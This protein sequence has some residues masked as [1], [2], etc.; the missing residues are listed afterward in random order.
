[1][2]DLAK[3]PLVVG[4]VYLGTLI[5]SLLLLLI[6]FCQPITGFEG[7]LFAYGA[8]QNLASGIPYVFAFI[9]MIV[10][11]IAIASLGLAVYSLI[12][13]KNSGF[14][15]SNM[16]IAALALGSIIYGVVFKGLNGTAI[17][18][19]IAALVFTIIS[20]A[21][22]VYRKKILGKIVTSQEPLPKKA[23]NLSI[24]MLVVDVLELIGLFT[25]F[26]IPLY[27]TNPGETSSISL[28]LSN[29]L[30]SASNNAT[31]IFLFIGALILFLISIFT[32]LTMIPSFFSD[33]DQFVRSSTVFTGF[34]VFLTL[35]FFLTG[36][37]MSYYV[38]TTGT[39]TSTIAYVPLIVIGVLSLAVSILKGQ[40]DLAT[41]KPEDNQKTVKENKKYF[42]VEPLIYLGLM[43]VMTFVSLAL[44]VIKM[45]IT[46]GSYIS[47]ITLTGYKLLTSYTT[48]G[49]GYQ[50]LAV[51][52]V[53]MLVASGFCLLWSLV[54]FFTHYPFFGRVVKVSAYVNVFLMFLLGISGFYFT[55]AQEINKT[56]LQSLLDLYNISI[57]GDYTYVLSTDAFYALIVDAVLLSVMIIR[58]AFNV[59]EV[60]P[61]AD[62][63]NSK[64]DSSADKLGLGEPAD[65]SSAV[66]F[67]PCPAFTEI[68]KKKDDYEADLK[69]REKLLTKDDSLNGLVKFVVNYAKDSRLHLSYSIEDMATFVSGLGACRLSILQGMS[70]TGKTSLP[71][72]FMEAIDG[73]CDLVEVESSWKDKNELL[74]Y[75]NEFSYMFTPRKFTQDLYKAALNPD[76][77]TF[78]VLDEMNL[79]RI[80]Y[81]FSDFLSLME[82]EEDKRYLKLSNI[83]LEK[84]VEGEKST[85]LAL[86]DGHTLKVPKN[87]WFIGTANRDE[88]TFIISDKVYDRAHT[89]NFNKRAPKVRDY[90]DPLP[91]QFYTYDKL[92][93]MLDKAIKSGTFDAEKNELIQKTEALLIPYN[94]SFG[95]RILNQIETFVN[96]YQAC[97]PDKNVLNQAIE[98]ILFSKVVSKLEMKTIDDKEGLAK[99]FDKLGLYRCSDFIL[100]LNED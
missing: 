64:D 99:S 88:S 65:N 15:A 98:T 66:S 87:V 61:I 8:I 43:T 29:A 96:I 24:A 22:G 16:I 35:A 39:P 25:I 86:Q 62:I 52:I 36:F 91:Q 57:S 6:G 31:N 4:Y 58:H 48:L 14:L 53:L 37:F 30:S 7:N 28:I 79:S 38:A 44:N 75:Y 13:K 90:S 70:G 40:Y 72:I 1:M 97:F 10:F 42:H 32:L 27:T 41:K 19:A 56:S 46:Y 63:E 71:K 59:E 73:D 68:D 5:F 81:Y 26:L 95:N 92:A 2:K 67:D 94:I 78:I 82:N 3:N 20:F 93:S 77:P 84:S 54:S 11:F 85:Y 45:K 55:I 51:Y 69:N 21:L 12:K 18:L 74:G 47:N 17:G 100:H 9:I 33:H 80:E 83:K 76:I 89:M 60:K 49:S 50:L 23:Q 34:N